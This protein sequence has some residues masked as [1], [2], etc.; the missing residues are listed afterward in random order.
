MK[1][2]TPTESYKLAAFAAL[3]FALGLHFGLS[4]NPALLAA[5]I[6]MPLAWLFA[7][8]R[9]HAV[10]VAIVYYATVARGVPKGAAIFFGDGTPNAYIFGTLLWLSSS[11]ALAAPWALLWS[12]KATFKGKILRLAAAYF[13]V[14]I[15]PIGLFGWGSPLLSAGVIF[16]NASWLGLAA[17]IILPPLLQKL[18]RRKEKVG[19][20]LS[21]CFMLFVLAKAYIL[22]FSIQTPEGFAALDTHHAK[23]ASGS[24]RF[25]DAFIRTTDTIPRVIEQTEPYI[26]LP[27]TLAGAWT[28]ASQLL[29]RPVGDYLAKK[30]QTLI[31]GTEIYN[32][33]GKYDNCMIFL[34]ADDKPIYRQRV[35]VP[36]SMWLPF[37]GVGTANAYWFDNGHLKLKDGRK[38][39]ILLCYEQYLAWPILLSMLNGKADVLITS[40]NQWWSKGTSIPNIQIQSSKSWAKLFS[41]EYISATNN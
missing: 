2:K 22:P 37:G 31:L 8:S 38:A 16:P 10:L 24:I 25:T 19:T 36:V 33:D 27:E 5:T 41:L 9:L 11:A 29:W 3:G 18:L 35:P 39:V 1:L 4:A 23:A 20:A 21:V 14:T 30:G 28:K 34:G 12:D 26:L 6:F 32:E 15:P 40:A 13:F 17:P 7:P